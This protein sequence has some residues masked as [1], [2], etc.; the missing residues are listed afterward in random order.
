MKTCLFPVAVMFVRDQWES[1]RSRSKLGRSGTG[2]QIATID[3]AMNVFWNLAL[4]SFWSHLLLMFVNPLETK[5]GEQ[6]VTLKFLV[7]SGQTPIQC[8]R[9]L[10]QVWGDATMCKTQVR[11]WHKQFVSGQNEVKD[12]ARRGRPRT[13]CTAGNFRLIQ[14]LIQENGHLSLTDL[15]DRTGI[16][17]STIRTILKKD[18]NMTRR[19]AKFV[20]HELSSA[21]METR[22]TICQRNIDLVCKQP[23]PE[24]FIQGII[25]G[26]EMWLCTSTL[27]TKVANSAWTKKSDPRPKTLRPDCFGRKTMLTLFCDAKGVILIDFLQ[28]GAAITAEEYCRTM[29]K[30]K[31]AIRR[32]RPQLW[33]GRRFLIHHDNTSPHTAD[34]TQLLMEKWGMKILDHPPYSPDLTPCDFSFFPKLKADLRGR[35]FTNV[36][37]LQKEARHLLFKMDKQV[38]IDTMHDIVT[39]W[40]KCVKAEGAYFE[41]DKVQIDPLFVWNEGGTTTDESESDDD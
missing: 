8:W 31:D 6:R 34:D 27:D 26:D 4:F 14:N 38:F 33:K 3:A 11:V 22:K 36:A 1:H 9:S 39:R 5:R 23:D 32:K 21:Q 2:R 24:E 41:G 40:Q 28:P 37:E 10:R 18:L 13:R 20:P 25:T 19:A 16:S 12:A 17:R 29:L 7:K 15:S 35:R 30:L